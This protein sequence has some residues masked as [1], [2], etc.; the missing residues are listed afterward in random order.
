MPE[1]RDVGVGR[2]LEKSQSKRNH[3]QRNQEKAVA[4]D[5][6]GRVEQQRTN[7]VEEKPD[8]DG[9]LVS[10][11]ADHQAGGERG[12]EITDV[13][14][15]LDEARLRAGERQCFLKLTDQD[16]IERGRES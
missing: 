11:T 2:G 15:Q 10:G 5:L 9:P 4:L 14:R 13:K 12:A 1:D 6:G 8:D 16:V 3:I 7:G